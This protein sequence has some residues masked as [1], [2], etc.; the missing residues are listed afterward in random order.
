[1]IESKR[2][3]VPILRTFCG[4]RYPLVFGVMRSIERGLDEA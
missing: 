4:A 1:M 2:A 3:D